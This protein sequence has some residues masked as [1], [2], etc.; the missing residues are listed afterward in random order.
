MG[1]PFLV[2]RERPGN[3][4]DVGEMMRLFNFGLVGGDIDAAEGRS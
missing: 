4:G 3:E 2:A 1:L